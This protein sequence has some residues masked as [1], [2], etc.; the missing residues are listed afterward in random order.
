MPRLRARAPE[1]HPERAATIALAHI[2]DFESSPGMASSFVDLV[3]ETGSLDFEPHRVAPDLDQKDDR[4]PDVTIYD[5]AEKPRVFVEAAF[6]EGVPAGQ[7]VDYLRELPGDLP[8]AFVYI[9]PRKRIRSLW[10]ILHERCAGDPELEVEDEPPTDEAVRARVGARVLLVASRAYV[11]ETLQ[12]TAAARGLSAIRT[13][14]RPTP[15][16]CEGEPG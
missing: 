9:A 6:W 4:Q 10:E 7:P 12:E 11:L 3:G 15:Q 8:S 13:G 1:S 2:L 5:A 14:N 16:S